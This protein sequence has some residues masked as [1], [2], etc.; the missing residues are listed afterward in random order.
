MLS[1]KF[2]YAL[3]CIRNNTLRSFNFR[4]VCEDASDIKQAMESSGVM[5][6]YDPKSYDSML[7]LCMTYNMAVDKHIQVG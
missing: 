4:W 6:K 1:F 3:N 2:Y 5:T 7:T